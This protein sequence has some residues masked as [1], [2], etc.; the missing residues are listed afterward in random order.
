MQH[1]RNQTTLYF[2]RHGETPSNAKDVQQGVQIDDYLDSNGV[3]E[4]Q[5]LGK[6]VGHLNLDLL[7][8][9]HLHRA[10]E[11]AAIINHSLKDLVQ[12][13]HD[14][15]LS[16]RDFGTLSGKTL[17]DWDNILPNHHE[18]EKMQMYDY[19]AFGGESVDQ[20]RHRVFQALIDITGNHDH[21][22]IGIVTHG[23]V[24]RLLLFHFPEIPRIYHDSQLLEKEI[25]N[26]DIYEW[27]IT[28][29][30]IAN[31]KSLLR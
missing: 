11:T 18:L 5:R 9:S 30:K 25:G 1:I 4:V 8:T 24:I 10:E 27:E 20:V 15:R 22:N 12:V 14:F 13:L 7:F 31:M 2:I 19:R 28:E 16:E 3:L 21:K 26:T 17:K 6:I 23:G 29:S